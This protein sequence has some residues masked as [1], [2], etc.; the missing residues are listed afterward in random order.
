MKKIISKF[1]FSSK[2]S[3]NPNK[4]DEDFFK[5][6]SIGLLTLG[7]AGMIYA[8]KHDVQKR[9]NFSYMVENFQIPSKNITEEQIKSQTYEGKVIFISGRPILRTFAFDPLF[10]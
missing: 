9:G 5:F 8:A 3:K 2:T 7:T 6:L 1:N 10:K 4:N